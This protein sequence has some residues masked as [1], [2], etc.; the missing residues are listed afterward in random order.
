MK[1]SIF[2]SASAAGDPASPRPKAGQSI[3]GRISGPIPIL[4][5]TDDEFPVRNPGAGIAMTAGGDAHDDQLQHQSSA[6]PDFVT[7]VSA[8]VSRPEIAQYTGSGSDSGRELA[9]AAA[10]AALAPGPSTRAEAL[11]TPSEPPPAVPREPPQG[12]RR[13]NPPST[14]RYSVVSEATQG[15]GSSKGK[16]QRKKSTLRGAFSKLFGRRKKSEGQS[17]VSAQRVSTLDGRP[18]QQQTF[19]FQEPPPMARERKESESKRSASLPITEFDRALR[20]HSI[21][22]S[23]IHAIE[24]AR[25]SMHAEYGLAARRRATITTSQIFRSRDGELAGLSPRPVST[26]A[27]AH[28]RGSR[29]FPM[30]ENPDEI[31]RAITSD[32]LG[33]RRRSRSLNGLH[34]VEGRKVRRRSDE[35]RY[36]RQSH[37]AFL[38]PTSS[39][40]PQ[41]SGPD[42]ERRGGDKASM[43]LS[44]QEEEKPSQAAVAL[45]FNFG[46]F[47]HLNPTAGMKITQAVS[48]ETR[49]DNLEARMGRME[50]MVAQLCD[51]LPGFQALPELHNPPPDRPPPPVPVPV[52]VPA[53]SAM[54][55]ESP[56]YQKAVPIRE[57]DSPERSPS[58]YSRASQRSSD[59]GPSHVASP[60]QLSA[61][62]FHQRPISE[63]TIRETADL[64]MA[65]AHL[66]A[67]IASR[68]VLEARVAALTRSLDSLLSSQQQRGLSGDFQPPPTARSFGHVS[69]FDHDDSDEENGLH[70]KN[71]HHLGPEDSGL[72]TGST[73]GEDDYSEPFETPREELTFGQGVAYQGG[74]HYAGG[75]GEGEGEGEDEEDDGQQQHKKAPRTMSLGQL[76]LGRLYHARTTAI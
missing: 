10:A 3:R 70:S 63:A 18:Q 11:Q 41:R 34:N 75:E 51:A 28:A 15:T 62:S 37:E 5:P 50:R 20:S 23:D 74:T 52:P 44:V 46:D 4:I 17:F 48:L 13:A 12:H 40:P 47:T 68:Q 1:V 69:A 53:T 14:V 56:A 2:K 27:H 61:P 21:G 72:A 39:G 8:Q 59:E 6:P 49:I 64:P 36:W 31:G 66:E 9:A 30:E 67:E 45:P 43:D 16:P 42:D 54:A 35:I 25:N 71:V 60:P 24:S 22:L 57:R 19:S 33:H 58:G 29:L 73:T 26:H 32:T 55:P 65:L 7:P 76:T 38:S